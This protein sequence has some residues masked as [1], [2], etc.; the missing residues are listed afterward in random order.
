LG[1]QGEATQATDTWGTEHDW[2]SFQGMVVIRYGGA[3]IWMAQRQKSTAL[4][5]MEAEIMAASEGARLVVWLEKLTRDLG[6]RDDD[7]FIPTLYCDN[8][9][10]VDLSYDT[11]HY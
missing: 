8:K 1:G 3:V 9:S 6:E 11:K 2:I 10:M 4:S 5:S 7:P